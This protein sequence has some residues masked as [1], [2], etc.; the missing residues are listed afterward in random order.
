MQKKVTPLTA[1][2]RKYGAI[3]IGCMLFVFLC[4]Y[5]LFQHYSHFGRK[6]D[7]IST[8]E[9]KI[10]DLKF[11][12]RGVRNPKSNIGIL[13]IDEKT[14]QQFGSWPFSRKYYGKALQNLKKYGVKWVGFDAIFA[15]KEK[16]KLE[17]ISEQLS[18]LRSPSLLDKEQIWKEMQ[19][20]EAVAPGDLAFAN[21]IRDFAHVVLGYFYF[22]REQEVKDG[23]RA[24]IAF[25]GLES[26]RGSEISAVILPENQTLSNYPSFLEAKGIV[27][28][29]EVITQAGTQFG[30]FSNVSDAD[31]IVRWVTQVKII[32][33]QVMPSLSL[34]MAAEVLDSEILVTFDH[35]GVESIELVSRKDESKGMKIPLDP[36]GEG[37]VLVNHHGP[38]MTFRHFSLAD[39]Y[40]DSFTSEEKEALRDSIL[41]IGMTAVGINDQR[42]NPFDSTLDGVENHASVL[43]NILNQSFLQR[44]KSIYSLELLI[45]LLLG[46]LFAPIMILTRAIVSGILMLLFLIGYWYFDQYFVFQKGIWAYMGMPI[47]EILS[48]YTGITLYKYTTEEREKKKV[49]GAFAH[50]L[51]ADVIKQVLEKPD[52][53]KLGGERKDLTVFFSDVRGF[54]TI[55][56]G[57]SPEKLCEFMN[58]YFTVMTKIVLK[59][60]GVLDKYIGDA[61]MAFWGAPMPIANQADIAADAAISMLVALERLQEEFAKKGFPPCDIGI[62]LNSGTMSVG[63]MGSQERFCY[64]VMGD[65][66]NLGSRLESL[67]KEYGVKIIVSEYTVARFEKKHHLLREL[68]DIR[69]KG[70]N[71][72]VKIYQLMRPDML[73]SRSSIMELTGVFLEGRKLYR[74]QKWMEAKKIFMNCIEIFPDDGPSLVYLDRIEKYS[75]LEVIEGWDGVFTFTHK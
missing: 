42:P 34:K 50:Y 61:I 1:L 23:G 14:L 25:S 66:V 30:F 33:N 39:A 74:E 40:A 12:I 11:K 26:M 59:S 67:T 46:I 70:K 32:N 68:D 10:L 5:V 63:N 51:S 73:P 13:A 20:F 15:E 65:A 16:A 24:S 45:I 69:V 37:R 4:W 44:P 43:D 38:S 7:L 47:F 49:R 58:D 71:E 21:G 75:A 35:F 19:E 28:N 2:A 57:L 22:E 55:S 48:L 9:T 54:T 41:L 62:G 64:T 72:P 27:P 8:V 31:A 52:M 53:L 18:K 56:E 3:S 6:Q 36:F 17:D 29:T 60:G